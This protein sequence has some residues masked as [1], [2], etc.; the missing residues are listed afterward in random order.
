MRQFI[1]HPF[2]IPIEACQI[3]QRA[4]TST[5][6]AFSIGMGGLAFRSSTRLELGAMVHLRIPYVDPEFESDARVVWCKD[7]GA[8]AEMGVEFVNPDDAYKARMVEQVCHIE[9]YRLKVLRKEGRELTP[10]EAAL[11]W[12]DTFAADF[13][14]PGGTAAN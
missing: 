13:P 11:E 8:G 14:N 9:D 10:E 7:N 4:T 3:G 6:P 5:L 2:S 1:R 12:I